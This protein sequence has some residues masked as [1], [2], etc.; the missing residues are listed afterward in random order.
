MAACTLVIFRPGLSCQ[1]CSNE[2]FCSPCFAFHYK[3]KIVG[4]H[5]CDGGHDLDISLS[6]FLFRLKVTA[7]ETLRE[8]V[9]LI[10]TSLIYVQAIALAWLLIL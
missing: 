1:I 6:D 8:C 3:K 9:C 2:Y 5:F 7:L 4:I 10:F